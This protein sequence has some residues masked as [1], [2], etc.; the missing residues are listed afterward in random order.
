MKLGI[1]N[2]CTIYILVTLL[3]AC[4]GAV[5]PITTGDVSESAGTTSSAS[6]EIKT[7]DIK[8][9]D[10]SKST[11]TISNT[12]VEVGSNITGTLTLKDSQDR[13]ITGKAVTIRNSGGA[14]RINVI[15]G[16]IDNGDGTYSLSIRGVA[17]GSATLLIAKV[18]DVSFDENL[19]T[20]INSVSPPSKDQSIIRAN[21]TSLNV[22]QSTWVFLDAKDADGN[23]V[24]TGGAS[25][26][27]S[28][29]G[30][31]SNGTFLIPIYLGMGVYVT[32]FT[33]TV[34]GSQSLISATINGLPLTTSKPNITVTG[35]DPNTAPSIGSGSFKIVAIT[36]QNGAMATY[37]EAAVN[38]SLA[39]PIVLDVPS[40]VVSDD[41]N[42]TRYQYLVED[43][44]WANGYYDPEYVPYNPSLNWYSPD[45]LKNVCWKKGSRPYTHGVEI[46]GEFAGPG[47][48]DNIIV[49]MQF[50]NAVNVA[51]I[52]LIKWQLKPYCGFSKSSLR[53][54]ATTE[55]LAQESID[56][57]G[58]E[59][60]PT[61]FTTMATYQLDPA[62]VA[63]G[64]PISIE[65]E[66]PR[67]QS[68]R[69]IYSA[70]ALS[71][72]NRIV[73]SVNTA[74]LVIKRDPKVN[75]LLSHVYTKTCND[76]FT[77]NRDGS[78]QSGLPAISIY[79]DFGVSAATVTV[80]PNFQQSLTLTYDKT[81]HNQSYSRDGCQYPCYTGPGQTFTLQSK[82][83][84]A[85][86][87]SLTSILADQALSSP[88]LTSDYTISV[89]VTNSIG[90][91]KTYSHKVWVPAQSSST[92]TRIGSLQRC[93][94]HDGSCAYQTTDGSDVIDV[95]N[96]SIQKSNASVVE[97]ETRLACGDTVSQMTYVFS[98]INS[99]TGSVTTQLSTNTKTRESGLLVCSKLDPP[100]SSGWPIPW[101]LKQD[102][103][104]EQ[105]WD[106]T[107][108]GLD[109]DYYSCKTSVACKDWIGGGLASNASCGGSSR[110]T[111]NDFIKI[112]GTPLYSTSATDASDTT[113]F[114]I[115]RPEAYMTVDDVYWLTSSSVLKKSSN[116]IPI[117]VQLS[118][119]VS[120]DASQDAKFKLIDTNAGN[121]NVK[122]ITIP[123]GASSY[124]GF[125]SLPLV[126]TGGSSV[127]PYPS[128]GITTHTL[129]LIAADSNTGADFRIN[130]KTD[131][132]QNRGIFRVT[133]DADNP[134]TCGSGETLELIQLN[135]EYYANDPYQTIGVYNEGQDNFQTISTNIAK[136]YN[137]TND[138][139][140]NPSF[141]ATLEEKLKI[142]EPNKIASL[143]GFVIQKLYYN[144]S[145]WDCGNA[146]VNADHCNANTGNAG[147]QIGEVAQMFSFLKYPAG[148]TGFV[149]NL[150][151]KDFASLSLNTFSNDT[152]G[153]PYVRRPQLQ[154][155]DM[156]TLY[157]GTEWLSNSQPKKIA[158]LMQLGYGTIDTI[159]IKKCVSP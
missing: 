19:L 119:A 41:A 86:S 28:V 3:N 147:L 27:F 58:S 5:S 67:Q 26:V 22:G 135:K 95:F 60:G 24:T 102:T 108:L 146:G 101:Y 87:N 1:F 153:V 94:T 151:N 74:H 122:S 134:G 77:Y 35:G 20:V 143:K 33:G 16:P 131:S 14:S 97:S 85:G 150:V 148:D 109:S 78:P 23:F 71:S 76:E 75:F 88:I 25:I 56:H 103:S 159:I 32:S 40:T 96:N 2:A 84:V 9:V 46:S 80:T 115:S 112:V 144:D 117:N 92:G 89:S 157:G 48:K 116:Q 15:S 50:T 82:H 29:V 7:T 128:S 6:E 57:C 30:G 106:Y 107:G 45:S 51:T 140:Y 125:L 152:Y 110:V 113:F 59:I 104:T 100:N 139:N 158:D 12:S 61:N 132:E 68:G 133:Y 70:T 52:Q 129:K 154:V 54:G 118:S 73:S 34:P 142:A 11:F 18:D 111:V 121:A 145:V 123:K 90:V 79:D 136:D 141:D 4:S 39:T 8:I 53:P 126:S 64:T 98:K 124:T 65:C 105:A 21:D 38:N 72:D 42:K 10:P 49:E 69:Q 63:S 55:E 114:K 17:S 99:T 36:E 93:D 155:V 31:T 43:S 91:T 47:S 66:I 137:A 37:N 156:K 81:I 62:D 13:L 44:S 138:P 127:F 149:S 120:E 130:G 83:L